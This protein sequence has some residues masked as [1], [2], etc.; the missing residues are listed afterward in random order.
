MS[1]LSANG[2]IHIVFLYA[3]IILL[4]AR[5]RIFL[6]L[7]DFFII[8]F[9]IPKN[10]LVIVGDRRSGN[11]ALIYWILSCIA[12]YDLI[13]KY[14][15]RQGPGLRW[16]SHERFLF[17][18]DVYESVTMSGMRGLL[19]RHKNLFRLSSVAILSFED[20][21][22]LTV[23]NHPILSK[24]RI[25][26]V[27]RNPLD[28]I[29]SR[30]QSL[31]SIALKGYSHGFLFS[32]DDA[33]FKRLISWLNN[34]LFLPNQADR[35]IWNYDS[36]LQDYSY[37]QSFLSLLGIRDDIFPIARAGEGGGSSFNGHQKNKDKLYSVSMQNEFKEFL[38]NARS[39]Y[40]SIFSMDD[41]ARLEEFLALN[42]FVNHEN[43]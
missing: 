38:G 31:S 15:Q 4:W 26:R 24:L 34:D 11:H 3:K 14:G 33:W 6:P 17:I 43:N 29:A 7:I 40:P 32:M 2:H 39:K 10:V 18:N 1:H 37:R 41:E 25:I 9:V 12:G 19:L 5:D 42:N 13:K 21:S 30:Y 36:W 28:L 16:Y 22:A 20:A 8:H 35:F 23:V 27:T